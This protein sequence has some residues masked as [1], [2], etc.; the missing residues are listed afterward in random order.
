MWRRRSRTPPPTSKS[1]S[2]TSG[3]TSKSQ[4]QSSV[5]KWPLTK[6]LPRGSVCPILLPPPV[7]HAFPPLLLPSLLQSLCFSL[8]LSL[9]L[10]THK[11]TQHT[12]HTHSLS[13]SP[14]QP[15]CSRLIRPDAVLK[16]DESNSVLVHCRHGH[17]RSASVLVAYLMETEGLSLEDAVKKVQ[18]QRTAAKPNRMMAKQLLVLKSALAPEPEEQA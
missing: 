18:E 9:C 3:W 4:S 1:W 7:H 13:L 2:S 11:H 16:E 15:R 6:L 17:S 8:S 14:L 12:Q 10:H 5:T